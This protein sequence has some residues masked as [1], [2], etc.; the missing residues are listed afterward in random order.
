MSLLRR[1]QKHH[2]TALSGCIFAAKARIDNRI[3]LVQQQYLL[4]MS[5]QYGELQPTSG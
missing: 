3:K 4:Q 2:H 5:A 1:I